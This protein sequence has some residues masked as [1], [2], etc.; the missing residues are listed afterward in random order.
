MQ[1]NA[2]YNGFLMLHSK[3]R[4]MQHR[5]KGICPFRNGGTVFVSAVSIFSV[6]KKRYD[7]DYGKQSKHNSDDP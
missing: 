6:L 5:V 1:R 7:S 2:G 4:A 3:I